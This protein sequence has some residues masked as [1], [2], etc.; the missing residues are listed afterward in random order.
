MQEVRLRVGEAYTVKLA[1]LM[2]GGMDWTYT[3]EGD[4][5]AVDVS[6][7]ALPAPSTLALGSAIREQRLAIHA[8]HPG[9]ATIR[10]ALRR[11]FD[12]AAPVEKEEAVTVN[13]RA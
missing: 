2:S 10:F 13:I 1:G 9:K 5:E 8:L 7:V 4:E 3:V 6:N 11:S 12:K